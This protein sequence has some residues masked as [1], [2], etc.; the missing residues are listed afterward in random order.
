MQSHTRF[1]NLFIFVCLLGLSSA[2]FAAEPVDSPQGAVLNT[3][4]EVNELSFPYV[5]EIIGDN[6]NVRSGPGTNYYHCGK[7]NT[8]DR[9]KVVASKYSWSH[10]VPP[11]GSFSWISKQYVS[12]DPNNPSVGVVTGDSVRVYA[13][14]DFLKPMHST[15]MQL[16]LNKGDKVELMGQEQDDYYKIVPPSGAY[17]WVLTEYTKPIGAVG[18]VEVIVRPKLEEEDAEVENENETEAET[19]A[20]VETGAEANTPAVVPA[21]VSVESKKLKEY[22]AL[23]EQIK[24]EQAQPLSEQNYA[25]IK[26]ALVA[27]AADKEAGKA[28]RYAEFA[29]K[30]VERIELAQAV[31]KEV[32]L[33][34]SQLQDV[35]E[36]IE[37][38]RDTELAQIPELGGF[39]AVGQFQPS[40]IYG[41]EESVKHYRLLD[42]SGQTICYVLPE[43]PALEIDLSQFVGR[44]VGLMGIIEPHP[45][46]K[47]A[48]VRFTEITIIDTQPESE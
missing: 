19:A 21:M 25:E 4:A 43:G 48:L 16:E 45:Q 11:V 13:G 12:V 24:A 10:I 22:Y 46:T 23:V 44:K 37:Q 40:Q 7:L 33:Q 17:L 41:T 6:V 28:S 38:A 29:I 35:N 39:T 30:Q 31:G 27:L 36:Q 34:D 42:D 15:T 3:E 47:G 8:G 2:G 20:E 32:Q 26:K 9:V 1:I 18:E 5:G 14:S